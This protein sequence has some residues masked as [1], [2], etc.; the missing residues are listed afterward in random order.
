MQ[1]NCRHFEALKA[2]KLDVCEE[3][4]HHSTAIPI[5]FPE[6]GL[7]EPYDE[8]LFVV[9]NPPA[10]PLTQSGDGFDVYALPYM[11]DLSSVL[12]RT[13]RSSGDCGS[14]IQH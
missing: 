9:Q 13:W 11:R 5:H 10:K 14:E 3:F 7:L 8:K 2:D 6:N 1:S 12:R 4:L